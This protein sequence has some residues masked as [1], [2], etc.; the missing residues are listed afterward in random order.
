MKAFI[1][2]TIFFIGCGGYS[3]ESFIMS[4]DSDNNA[5]R[6]NIQSEVYRELM[7]NSDGCS[8]P[9]GFSIAGRVLIQTDNIL[10]KEPI[11]CLQD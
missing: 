11:I 3:R 7:D 4:Y 9:N 8:C 6:G 5:C 10:R 1:L 2:I